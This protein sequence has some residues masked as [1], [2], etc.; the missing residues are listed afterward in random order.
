MRRTTEQWEALLDGITP[1]EW[2]VETFHE[3]EYS[4]EAVLTVDGDTLAWCSYGEAPTALMT[5]EDA[6]L[7]SV[8]PEAVAEVVRLRREIGRLRQQ[9]E[10]QRDAWRQRPYPFGDAA[11]SLTRILEGDTDEA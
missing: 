2:G 8:A 3:A 5:L 11:R 7:A 6:A 9:V 4:P 1:G 10:R